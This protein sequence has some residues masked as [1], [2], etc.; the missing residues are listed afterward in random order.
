MKYKI[1]Y[2]PGVKDDIQKLSKK[3]REIVKRSIE[4][5]L[6]TEPEKYGSPLR[7]TLKGYWKLRV[8]DLRVVF[9]ISKSEILILAILHRKNVYDLAKKRK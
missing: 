4:E 9:K 5:R 2:H 3:Q 6:G 1:I 7:R 8:S